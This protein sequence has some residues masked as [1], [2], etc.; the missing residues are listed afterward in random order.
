MCSVSRGGTLV[1]R[2]SGLIL[3]IKLN[4]IKTSLMPIQWE[5]EQWGCEAGLMDKRFQPL[6]VHMHLKP[7]W[8]TVPRFRENNWWLLALKCRR[9]HFVFLRGREAAEVL[10]VTSISWSQ[11]GW[12]WF[13]L[14]FTTVSSLFI[15]SPDNNLPGTNMLCFIDSRQSQKMLRCAVRF[16]FSFSFNWG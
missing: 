4:V 5:G 16:F 6:H 12:R 1:R 14:L 7:R 8:Q 15:R 13:F 3:F 10:S 11:I 2:A 9:Y